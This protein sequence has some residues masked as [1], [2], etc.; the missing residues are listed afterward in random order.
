MARVLAFGV[1][2]PLHEGHRDF[3]RQARNVGDKLLVVVARDSALRADKQREP[4]QN[5]DER[6][7]AVQREPS[8]TEAVLG[9]EGVSHYELLV[10]LSFEVVVLGYD[11]K[12]SDAVVRQELD[13]RG[14]TAVKIVRLKPWHPDRFKSSHLR[15]TPGEA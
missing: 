3:F 5:E 13:A 1:F 12:P 2:D 15:P 4:Y 8:V 14:K 7:A 6:L 9:S 11:Q 10:Q